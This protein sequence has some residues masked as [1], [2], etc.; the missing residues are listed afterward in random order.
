MHFQYAIDNVVNMAKTHSRAREMRHDLGSQHDR[1]RSDAHP[2]QNRAPDHL[3]TAV[4]VNV[5]SF[6]LRQGLSLDLVM[7]YIA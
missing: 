5:R 7:T 3:A 4:A 1:P 2:V 6:R